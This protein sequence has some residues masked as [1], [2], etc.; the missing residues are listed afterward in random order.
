MQSIM[1]MLNEHK[2]GIIYGA[3]HLFI[4]LIIES[5]YIYISI[6][7]FFFVSAWNQYFGISNQY[8]LLG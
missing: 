6:Q 1:K 7:L 5:I 4:H 2:N 8:S 3:I